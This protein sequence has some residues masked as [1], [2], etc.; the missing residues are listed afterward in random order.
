MNTFKFD[1]AEYKKKNKYETD[2]R[3]FKN[4][5]QSA[6]NPENIKKEKDFT[7]EQKDFPRL[8]VNQGE[9]SMPTSTP[10]VSFVDMMKESINAE[11]NPSVLKETVNPG[12]VSISR[13]KETSQ[14]EWKWG[15]KTEYMKQLEKKE[16]LNNNLSYC[17][18][19]TIHKMHEDY[20]KYEELYDEIYG[21]GAYSHTYRYSVQYDS[22]TDDESGNDETPGDY[23]VEYDDDYY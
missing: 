8:A 3:F 19:K 2:T 4:N 1:N 7:V 11:N 6:V 22:V 10:T 21:D 23:S 9:S 12:W 13:N 5:L 16:Q 14:I 18:H 20:I 15:D 17:M